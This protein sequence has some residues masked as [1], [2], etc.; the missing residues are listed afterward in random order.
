MLSAFR[1]GLGLSFAISA[2]ALP[3]AIAG[4]QTIRGTVVDRVDSIP[5]SGVVVL[6]LDADGGVTA[7]ALTNE[8]GEYR[9]SAAGAGVY[10][11]RT[12]RIGFRP[13][14]SEPLWLAGGQELTRPL[15]V[16]GVPF[17]LDT[18]RV[19]RRSTCRLR[20]D[21]ALVT[22]AIW[23]QVRTALTATDL[24]TRARNMGATIVTYDRNLDPKSRRV[25]SQTSNVQSGITTKP[26][27][28]PSPDS[29]RR[30]GYVREVNSWF[31]YTAPDLDALLSTEFLED[32]C[33][34]VADASDS[35][36]LG[37]GFEPTR[38]RSRIPEIRGV[39]WLDRKSAELRRME[40][41][42][43]N[44]AREQEHGDAGGE[45]DF[46]RTTN[47]VWAIASWNIRMPLLTQT[48]FRSGN[49]GDLHRTNEPRFLVTELKVS[50]GELALL[51]RGRDTLWSRP[52]LTLSGTV[53]DSAS[54]NPIPFALVSL[55]GTTF[56]GVS[57]SGGTFT[58]SG[59]LPG[60]Y[61]VQ[62]RT[63]ALD[64]IAMLFQT[65]L[66]FADAVKATDLRLPSVPGIVSRLCPDTARTPA[67]LVVGAV[68][69]HGDTMPKRNVHVVAE[70][71]SA[72]NK[73]IGPAASTRMMLENT[74]NA[75]EA[76]T[77]ATG[78]Y[79]ICGVPIGA[80]FRV[81]SA[82]DDKIAVEGR[83]P[84]DARFVRLDVV[85]DTATRSSARSDVA[86]LRGVVW[87]EFQ[88]QSMSGAEVSL[89]DVGLST[90][91]DTNGAFQITDIPAG[92]HRV[93]VRQ[94]GF[95]P[96]SFEVDF[97][98]NVSVARQFVLARAQVLDS[99]AITAR[100][101]GIPEFE[102]RRKLRIGS[103][104]TREELAT[105]ENRR[106]SEVLVRVGGLQVRR[107]TGGH[108]AWITSGRGQGSAYEPDKYSAAMGA[109]RGCYVDIWLDGVRVYAGGQDVLWDVNGIPPASLEA[110]EY[111]A[112]PAQTPARYMRANQACGTLVLW[113]RRSPPSP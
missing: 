46:V 4:A 70:W 71:S 111:Y 72:N 63:P 64:S 66:T 45:M 76:R 86:T 48:S 21:S 105:Q 75:L 80:A 81:R 51:T 11:V 94:I 73:L 74:P 59:V 3:P 30:V 13:V 85:V 36:R 68:G 8:R 5:I 9:L 10:R 44:I 95:V 101:A 69:M 31:V 28:S 37:L 87:N 42:Y 32:H 49:T 29:L 47:G 96:L 56:A 99:V 83:I 93:T 15:A 60:E 18:V 90:K 35:S 92:P 57:D 1:V 55:R 41:Q 110:V 14:T 19:Q 104:I 23:E 77:D 78:V 26:W 17:S 108:Q 98:G 88:R 107:A 6:L 112:G 38:E 82:L 79:R 22:Y 7:R 39:V 113:T 40:F 2:A 27:I 50:G 84:S 100:R 25:R 12:L 16:A 65:D 20:T 43:T 58:L 89:T 33:F 24:S 54:G 97:A 103:F 53:K 67:G 106:M 102:E 52:P 91:S 34:R 62:V 61:T 109:K